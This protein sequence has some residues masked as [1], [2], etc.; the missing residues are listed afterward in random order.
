MC[1]TFRKDFFGGIDLIIAVKISARKL[2]SNNG[3]DGFVYNA[4]HTFIREFRL[5]IC[6]RFKPFC[7]VRIIKYVGRDLLF[8]AL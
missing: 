2:I 6:C 7:N 4:A 3:I 8:F 5:Q 1:S